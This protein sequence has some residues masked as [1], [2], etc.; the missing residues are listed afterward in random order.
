MFRFNDSKQ[1]KTSKCDMPFCRQRRSNRLRPLLRHFSRGSSEATSA[2][3]RRCDPVFVLKAKFE[4]SD[5]L[6][7]TSVGQQREL[8]H[9]TLALRLLMA[10]DE[11]ESDPGRALHQPSLPLQEVGS[12]PMLGIIP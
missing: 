10:A 12:D 3:V 11:V 6:G 5:N 1:W 4:A 7:K 9:H 8:A 2:F